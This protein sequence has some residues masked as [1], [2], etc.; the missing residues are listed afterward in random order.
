MALIGS[1]QAELLGRAIKGR[2]H[3]VAVDV[4]ELTGGQAPGNAVGAGDGGE[5]LAAFVARDDGGTD[6]VVLIG[7]T[8]PL[9]GG[10]DPLGAKRRRG[11]RRC[12]SRGRRSTCGHTIHRRRRC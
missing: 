1:L 11:A 6:V 8:D 9:W 5:A 3:R 7:G 12:G 10:A 2:R 4:E